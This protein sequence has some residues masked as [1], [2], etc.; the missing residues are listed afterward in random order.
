MPAH[1]SGQDEGLAAAQNGIEELKADSLAQSGSLPNP[2]IFT[3]LQALPVTNTY[4]L[5]ATTNA[6]GT[7]DP[8]MTNVANNWEIAALMGVEPL[9]PGTVYDLWLE[10]DGLATHG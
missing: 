1:I 4:V 8:L 5:K 7:F 6:P 9:E 2:Q 10:K 3:C